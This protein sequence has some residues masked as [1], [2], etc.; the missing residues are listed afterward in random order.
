MELRV[1]FVEAD[2]FSS[3][4]FSC[5]SHSPCFVFKSSIDAKVGASLKNILASLLSGLGTS[6]L[7]FQECGMRIFRVLIFNICLID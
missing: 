2:E 4:E 7:L 6:E 3:H 5:F 1:E